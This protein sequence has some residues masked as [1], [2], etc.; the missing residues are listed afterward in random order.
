MKWQ[1]EA[2]SSS[3][4]KSKHN[5]MKTPRRKNS[6]RLKNPYADKTSVRVYELRAISSYVSSSNRE[7]TKKEESTETH[8]VVSHICVS[9]SDEGQLKNSKWMLFNDFAV[10]VVKKG[11]DDV[12]DFTNT[13]RIPCILQYVSTGRWIDFWTQAKMEILPAS[14]SPF[15]PQ[16]FGKKGNKRLDSLRRKKQLSVSSPEVRNTKCTSE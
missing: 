13:N 8:H 15:K 10:S 1:I 12:I 6:K 14:I 16:L 7:E 11:Y 4:K 5:N 9:Q 2:E 3:S